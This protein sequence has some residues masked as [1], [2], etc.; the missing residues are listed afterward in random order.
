MIGDDDG[1][2]VMLMVPLYTRSAHAHAHLH[3]HSHLRYTPR[4][5][6]YTHYVVSNCLFTV[7]V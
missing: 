4:L 7:R 5:R 6:I 2:V 3:L 1:D